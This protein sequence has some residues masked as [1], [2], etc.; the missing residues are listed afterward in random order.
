MSTPPFVH[1]HVHSEYSLLDGSAKIEELITRAKEMGMDSIAITDHGVMYGAIDFYRAANKE[2]IKP[3]LG[4]EVYVAT[5][6]RHTKNSREDGSGL[7]L[8][9]LAENETGYHNL[10]KLVSLG[11]TEGFYY[12]PRV[13]LEVLQQYC[14]GL[15]ALSACLGGVVPKVLLTKGYEAGKEAA[16]MYNDMFGQGN[17]Y[18]ELQDHGLDEQKQINQM[19][20]RMSKET[21]IP[22]VAA[23]DSH[24]IHES[25]AKA[26]DILLCIQTGKTVHDQER[27]RFD[28]SEF[29]LKSPEEMYA[30]FPYAKEALENTQKIADRCHIDIE[31]NNYKLP[32]F[33][34]PDGTNAAD[35]LRKLC[36]EGLKFRY[37]DDA[38]LHQER[39]NHELSVITGMGFEDYF[40]VVGDFIKFSHDNGIIVGP[41]RGS[42][43]GSIVAYALRIT[44]VDPIPFDL[45]FERFLN[46]ERVSM[47]DFDIDF[48][49]ERRQE[50]ID[51]VVQK[52]GADH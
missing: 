16:L 42:G 13:D 50:V 6:S 18:L 15:I 14:Q 35:Y 12:R 48:C 49:Y 26:H 10:M 39:L 25:D 40:L 37:G 11:F 2:G 8:V 23:N 24:Y 45:L 33:P 9:L 47:P 34:I 5:G 27:M 52:Y 36:E 7:H 3:I 19:L 51:Y 32:K 46:P 44:D 38:H 41:G 29:Y 17:F 4:C 20:I 22:L 28:T 43:A 1:L 30:L 31:F 21:G